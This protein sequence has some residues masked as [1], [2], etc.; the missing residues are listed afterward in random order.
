M[1]KLAIDLT[2][3]PVGGA[4][5]QIKEIIKDIESF[6][7]DEVVFYV[8]MQNS[9][10]F[11]DIK[12][13]K[14]KLHIVKFSNTALIKRT[15]WTQITLPIL[16]IKQNIDVL[17]CPGNIAPIINSKRKAQ[18]IGTVGPFEKDFVS[19]FGWKQQ[20]ILFLNK[21]LIIMSSRTSDMVFFESD[22]TRDLFIEKY[23]QNRNYSSVLH[24]GNDEFFKPV[25]SI[26]SNI[27]KNGSYQNFILTVSHLYPYK[28]LEI[29]IKSFFKLRL[30][31]KK[32]CL[33]IAGSILDKIYYNKLKLLVKKYKITKNVIFLGRV[34]K[35]DLRELYSN[36]KVFAFTS[37]FENFA[38]TL[39][40]A[41]SCSAPIIT[42]NTT[43]MPETCGEA[44]L[45]F[46]PSSEDEL[47]SRILFFLNDE[48][49]RSKYK[50]LSLK[51]SKEVDTYYTVN[52]KTNK[53]L[54]GL[55]EP[56]EFK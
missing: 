9:S 17:F 4:L 14:L 43:A 28:N 25:K 30:H 21:H 24:I 6:R 38:Y 49:I 42:T 16:L 46:S 8:T 53:I 26:E 2:Y 12:N 40:E 35:E 29:L 44:A 31:E 41:M 13:E 39:I 22:Y 32:M 48:K 10:L 11:S 56:N 5:T 50:A 47:C 52:K 37:P 51:K 7:F 54:E 18:W 55:I 15:F 36:C 23:N 33:L 3:N 34:E 27:L 1:P 45:Y 20:I 19:F